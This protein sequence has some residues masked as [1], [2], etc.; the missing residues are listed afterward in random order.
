[1]AQLIYSLVS[2]HL[3]IKFHLIMMVSWAVLLTLSLLTTNV[4]SLPIIDF[5]SK[6]PLP[7]ETGTYYAVVNRVTNRTIIWCFD[8]DLIGQ[9]P[10]D[11]NDVYWHRFDWYVYID[12]DIIGFIFKNRSKGSLLD[13]HSVF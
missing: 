5:E 7:L 10:D 12:I 9:T 3:S 13:I 6:E 4:G 8:L 2:V 11:D 1:M